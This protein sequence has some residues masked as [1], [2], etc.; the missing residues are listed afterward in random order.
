MTVTTE[1]KKYKFPQYASKKLKRWNVMDLAVRDMAGGACVF[2]NP[3]N[4]EID[5]A[6]V[7]IL[8]S[9]SWSEFDNNTIN[10]YDKRWLATIK[11][12]LNE[13]ATYYHYPRNL[14]IN[15]QEYKEI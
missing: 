14:V 7:S 3:L 13:W 2:Y 1:M 15:I 9:Y 5:V 6:Y 12:L 10:V 11:Q 8:N 4:P